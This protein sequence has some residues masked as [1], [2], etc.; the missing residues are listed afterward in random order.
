M[1]RIFDAHAYG[2]DP[3]ETNYWAGT[4]SKSTEGFSPL[5]GDASVDI[6]IIG[7]GFTGLNAAL[8]LA[9]NGVD[10]RVMEAGT[11]GFGASGRN[12]GF[13]CLGGAKAS[14]AKLRR[15]FGEAARQEYRRTEKQA[16][17][18]VASLLKRHSIDADTHSKGET[19]LAHTARAAAGL[20]AYCAEIET[21]Y[22]VVPSLHSHGDLTGLGMNGPFFGAITTP[23]GFALNP[24]KYL[25]GLA[26]AARNAGALIHSNSAVSRIE[27]TATGYLLHT[28]K[29]LIRCKSLIIATNGY[30]SEDLPDWMRARYLPVQS[31]VLVTRPLSADEIAAQGWS[32]QQMCYDSRELLHYFRL[33]PDGR[34][35][36]GMRGGVL[37][38][39]QSDRAVHARARQHFEAMFPAWRHVE[40]PHS[41]NG[42][43]CLSAGLVPFCG[44]IPEMPG[45]YA[46]F[47][48]HGN[49]V[50]M[51]S[52]T[53]ALLA[54][55]VL[56]NARDIP[57]VMRKPP[58]RFP[59]GRYRK[60]L[61]R[62]AYAVASLL[63][64]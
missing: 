51:G 56:G 39:Q 34:F 37:A 53:G 30:S 8:R 49:G 44:E 42:F 46:G 41:W 60:H 25:T 31:Q 17:D 57:Q 20:E 16:V 22:G 35:L 40:T 19:I 33:M 62:P 54:D 23:V 61:L 24:L 2:P 36:F 52:Y 50:A 55:L 7:G 26:A 47:A 48:Y 32:T 3:I 15:Q 9:E 28:A 11:P 38:T 1:K 27:K 58:K 21:D 29:G 59:L 12:G 64:R 6:A 18:H 14:N 45:A 4:V 10:V 43:V 13:C 63:D 5:E